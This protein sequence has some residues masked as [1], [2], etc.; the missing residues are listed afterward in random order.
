MTRKLTREEK[1]SRSIARRLGWL[2]RE[3]PL[4]EFVPDSELIK[5]ANALAPRSK[6]GGRKPPT[7]QS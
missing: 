4:S 6:T 7:R 2:A 1:A 3:L 5:R